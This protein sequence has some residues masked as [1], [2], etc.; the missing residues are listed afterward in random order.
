MIVM[1]L[2]R[3]FVKKMVDGNLFMHNR[4]VQYAKDLVRKTCRYSVTRHLS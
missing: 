3:S 1:I 2:F 4:D